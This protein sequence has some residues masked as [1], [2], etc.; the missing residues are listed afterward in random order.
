VGSHASENY[1][2]TLIAVKKGGNLI[3]PGIDVKLAFKNI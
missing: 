2:A 1:F 3:D